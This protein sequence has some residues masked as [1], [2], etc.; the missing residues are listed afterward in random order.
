MP[1]K[2]P[3]AMMAEMATTAFTAANP[4]ASAIAWKPI[5]KTNEI[6]VTTTVPAKVAD[7]NQLLG[8][9]RMYANIIILQF[10]LA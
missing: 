1:T 10:M 3:P 2:R 5:W 6:V 4:R 9:K 7:I 8:S